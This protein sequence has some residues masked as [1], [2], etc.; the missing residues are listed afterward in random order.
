MTITTIKLVGRIGT[1]LPKQFL[2]LK[3]GDYL[4]QQE[5]NTLPNGI[6]RQLVFK[7]AINSLQ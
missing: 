2:K 7:M 6:G 5:N 1:S 3:T 4:I